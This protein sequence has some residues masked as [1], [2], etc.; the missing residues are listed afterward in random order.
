ME[1][2]PPTPPAGGLMNLGMLGTNSG[3]VMM[4]QARH[5][6]AE[7]LTRS[8]MNRTVTFITKFSSKVHSKSLRSNNC[9]GT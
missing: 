1:P 9:L 8:N 6:S 2:V 3:N 4:P 7:H 5:I